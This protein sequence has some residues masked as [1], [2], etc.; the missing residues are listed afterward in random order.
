MRSEPRSSLLVISQV[1]RRHPEAIKAKKN[2]G[3]KRLFAR[4]MTKDWQ[5]GFK[6]ARICGVVNVPAS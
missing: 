3:Y 4:L 5:K 2:G 6:E 1:P